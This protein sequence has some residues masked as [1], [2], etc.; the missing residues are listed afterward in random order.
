LEGCVV[1]R[2]KRQR[3]EFT[4]E[5]N[6]ELAMFDMGNNVNHV[7]LWMDVNPTNRVVVVAQYLDVDEVVG[8]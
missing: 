3:N 4:R 2:I 6:L 1:S 7:G 5:G 8:E